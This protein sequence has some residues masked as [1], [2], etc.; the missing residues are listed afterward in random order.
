MTSE[1]Y[2]LKFRGTLSGLT[3]SIAQILTFAAIK[4]Y[5]DINRMFGLE[6]TLWIFSVAGFAGTVFALVGLPETRNCSLDQIES[7]FSSKSNL[8]SE[9]SKRAKQVPELNVTLKNFTYLGDEDLNKMNSLYSYDNFCFK[10]NLTD[11]NDKSKNQTTH[12]E[13]DNRSKVNQ[14]STISLE[15]EHAYL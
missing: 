3:T 1:L 14:I 5:P 11:D 6:T 10:L 9:D 2:P 13:T 7:R 8:W 15:L 12:S 4:T